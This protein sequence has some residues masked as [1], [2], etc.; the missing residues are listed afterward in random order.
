VKYPK[1]CP[2]FVDDNRYVIYGTGIDEKGGIEVSY[3]Q[4]DSEELVT[5]YLHL[6]L[7]SPDGYYYP[8]TP[9]AEEML[10]IARERSGA[11]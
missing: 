2:V 11:Q 9:A 8:A 7:F 10:A 6:K 3:P 4:H 5:Q 1:E